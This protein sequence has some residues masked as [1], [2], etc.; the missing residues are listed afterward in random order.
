M[1]PDLR[2]LLSIPLNRSI[3]S[4]RHWTAK[5]NEIRLVTI[6]PGAWEDDIKCTISHVALHDPPKY[7][8]LSY[9][10]G[11]AKDTG[12]IY[13]NNQ[14]FPATSSLKA[15]LLQ[16]RKIGCSILWIDAICID[17]TNIEEK[18]QQLPLIGSIYRNAITTIAWLGDESRTS[19]LAFTLMRRLWREEKESSISETK[20]ET[21]KR[22]VSVVKLV[23]RPL[24]PIEERDAIAAFLNLLRRPYWKR[25]WIIQ[26]LAFS[27]TIKILCGSDGAD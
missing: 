22:N 11:D 5:R 9:C 16:L 21:K 2:C 1:N 3:C 19:P 7:T 12:V 13:L 4:T 23:N 10:W 27:Q 14:V 26:E 15:A 24:V 17:Q 25:V 18:S 8:A 6:L 20:N